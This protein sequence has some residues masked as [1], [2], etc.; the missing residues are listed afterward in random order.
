M[1]RLPRH[2]ALLLL[3][4]A[5]TIAGASLATSHAQEPAHGRLAGEIPAT[6]H[7]AV[8]RAEQVMNAMQAALLTRLR[9]Q[10]ASGGPASAV[11]VCRDEAQVITSR[12]AR[13]QGIAMGRTSHALRNPANA[14]PAWA[15]TLVRDTAGSTA[16]TQGLRVFDLGDRVGVVR[17]I[18]FVDMCASC[19]GAPA[20][21]PPAIRDV[22]ATSYP[23]DAAVGF[24]PGD[25]RGWMWAEVTKP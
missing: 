21:L 2:A 10:I 7:P 4:I 19:H 25:L 20:A 8:A 17:P 18:G 1:R 14:A 15:A 24:A 23:R 13:E 6:L 12:V 22:L 5:A 3:T 9:D 11:Q 16:A